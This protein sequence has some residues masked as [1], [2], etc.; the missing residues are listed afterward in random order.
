MAYRYP[1]VLPGGGCSA[2]ACSSNSRPCT[3]NKRLTLAQVTSG[4]LSSTGTSAT[5][6]SDSVQFH[7]GGESYP[8]LL[9]WL[10]VSNNNATGTPGTLADSATGTVNYSYTGLI[11][12]G[13][14]SLTTLPDATNTWLNTIQL[15]VGKTYNITAVVGVQDTNTTSKT[16]T[17]DATLT[18]RT[19][20]IN[21]PTTSAIYGVGTQATTTLTIPAVSSFGII[22]LLLTGQWAIAVTDST[23]YINFTVLN[24][25]GPVFTIITGSLQITQLSA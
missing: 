3:A 16:G 20:S 11:S 12:P 14:T 5:S 13:Y 4:V 9:D 8:I 17:T 18:L 15:E 2:G 19:N 7:I 24:S 6:T 22:R 25:G 23:K 10:S 1:S 21:D